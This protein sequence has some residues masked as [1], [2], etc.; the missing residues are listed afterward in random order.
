MTTVKAT[1]PV[2]LVYGA[3]CVVCLE[4]GDTIE[5]S[6][7][8]LPT[9][10]DHAGVEEV[11]SAKKAKAPSTIEPSSVEKTGSKK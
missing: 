6:P 3:G 7:S 11:G 4:K 10:M 9:V 1:R 2:R 8:D 5:V